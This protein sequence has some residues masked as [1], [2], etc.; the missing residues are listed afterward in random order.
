M[1]QLSILITLLIG[2]GFSSVCSGKVYESLKVP[3]YKK[4]QVIIE[5][6]SENSVGI[7]SG[8]IET[9]VK[10]KLLR[11]GIKIT[12]KSNPY[13]YVAVNVMDLELGTRVVGVAYNV[14]I[15]LIKFDFEKGYSYLPW[16]S[17]MG[18]IGSSPSL[19]DFR[20]KF[21]NYL[22]IFILNYLESNME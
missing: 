2:L 18:V 15:G 12:P 14:T 10:L 8:N 3:N 6:V 1:K 4:I 7:T 17:S 11:N 19:G 13:I 20:T 5:N 22:D 21:D 9:A 16:D